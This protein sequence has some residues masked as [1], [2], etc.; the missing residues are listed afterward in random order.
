VIVY[1]RVEPTL[2]ADKV[3]AV[4][5]AAIM[6][7]ELPAGSRLRIRDIAEQV[8]TS[9][10]PVREAIRRLEES[11]LAERQPHKGTVVKALSMA[12]LLHVYDTRRLLEGEAARLGAAR[13]SEAGVAALEETYESML[14][15]I[16]R[17]Q[18]V[19]MLDLDEE[20]LTT[21]YRA[22]GNPVLVNTIAGLWRQ[23]RAYKIVGA[24]STVVDVDD[25]SLWRYQHKLLVAARDQ[26]GRAALA[27]S[28][29]SL[30]D[31]T[32]R[33]R[34]HLAAQR[35]CEEPTEGEEPAAGVSAD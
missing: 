3:H 22:S 21:L 20:L 32:A 8:G 35:A 1:T 26:D 25:D 12:E 31:A 24:A 34:A 27:A 14:A 28:N 4:L 17:G 30:E 9:V 6:S 23:C 19:E 15:A 7:G 5:H 10:M 13:I 16:K 11:G 29:G 2:L 18:I 33:I